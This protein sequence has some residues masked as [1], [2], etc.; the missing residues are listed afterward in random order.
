[1]IKKVF[2]LGTSRIKIP[3][4][5]VVPFPLFEV[6]D[7]KDTNDYL[8]RVEPSPQGGRKMAKALMEA[9]LA[10]EGEGW[11]GAGGDQ[12]SGGGTGG[13]TA[14]ISVPPG[15]VGLLPGATTRAA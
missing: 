1:M 6:L 2:E 12:A 7:G 8:Q 15:A 9:V 5:E 4:T 11:R 10:A 14:V 3:G 13:G